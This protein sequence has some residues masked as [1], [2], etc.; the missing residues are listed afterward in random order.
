MREGLQNPLRTQGGAR[1]SE[2]EFSDGI[3]GVPPR[4]DQAGVW[5]G[6]DKKAKA[7]TPPV[8]LGSTHSG[9]S[10]L[11]VTPKAPLPASEKSED[12]SSFRHANFESLMDDSS[13]SGV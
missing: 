9:V 13:S 5:T 12:S 11:K 7:C 10:Y 2:T 4:K 6:S 8:S 1:S 3:R